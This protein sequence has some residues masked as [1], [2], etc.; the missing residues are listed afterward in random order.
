MN[1]K[2]GWWRF[3]KSNHESAPHLAAV[4]VVLLDILPVHAPSVQEIVYN[5]IN[6]FLYMVVARSGYKVEK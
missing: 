5:I 4:Y 3:L 2:E 1:R 6:Q